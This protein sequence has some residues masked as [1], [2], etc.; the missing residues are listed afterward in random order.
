MYQFF[1]FGPTKDVIDDYVS[2]DTLTDYRLRRR[3]IFVEIF[4][5]G[6]TLMIIL[7]ILL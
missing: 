5:F 3:I 2:L 1:D 6:L 7:K 4:A